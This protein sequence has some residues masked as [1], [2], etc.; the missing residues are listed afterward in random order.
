MNYKFILFCIVLLLLLAFLH[1]VS[2]PRVSV[3]EG[4]TTYTFNITDEFEKL[5]KL[6]FSNENLDF[7]KMTDESY[8][9]MGNIMYYLRRE[10]VPSKDQFPREA[11]KIIKFIHPVLFYNG[12]D[13]KKNIKKINFQAYI[14]KYVSGTQTEIISKKSQIRKDDIFFIKFPNI[15]GIGQNLKGST[16]SIV[17]NNN[18]MKKYFEIEKEIFM[19][20]DREKIS[21]DANPYYSNIWFDVAR[22]TVEVE[23]DKSMEESTVDETSPNSENVMEQ[24]ETDANIVMNQVQANADNVMEQIQTNA[25]DVMNKVRADADNVL[26]KVQEDVDSTVEEIESDDENRNRNRNRSQRQSASNTCDKS[27]ASSPNVNNIMSQFFNSAFFEKISSSVADKFTRMLNSEPEEKTQTVHINM[28]DWVHKKHLNK[29]IRKTDIPT[30]KKVDKTKFIL[31]TDIPRCPPRVDMSKY[32]LKS[33][34]KPDCDL[35][36]QS[37]T[38]S[39]ST[40][41]C[42]R[43]RRNSCNGTCESQIQ[44][45]FTYEPY[46]FNQF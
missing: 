20:K 40:Q 16:P 46:N 36:R 23:D 15:T 42:R 13:D 34:M 26:E 32:V 44:T 1:H 28:D 45:Q 35:R 18:M 12:S 39:T 10:M 5:K 11:K 22:I 9:V 38:K 31:K 27:D 25:E 41:V 6:D 33:D 21:G 29:Y 19:R 2:T 3:E 24:I 4:F 17:V 30:C 43:C 37:Q 14:N 8:S 7:S